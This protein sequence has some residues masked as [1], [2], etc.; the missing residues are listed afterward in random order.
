MTQRWKRFWEEYRRAPVTRDDDLFVQVGRTIGGRAVSGPEFER[1]VEHVARAL[2]LDERDVLFEFCCGNGLL[3]Y[4]L[5]A[6]VDR[7]IASDFTEHLVETA[8]S[9][10]A[11]PNVHYHVADALDPIACL[12]PSGVLPTK[13]LMGHALA[14]FGPAELE[15]VLANV[16]EATPPGTF[17]F[18]LT[19]IPDRDRMWNFYDTPERRARYEELRRRGDPLNDGLGRWWTAAELHRI[20]ASRGL[21]ADVRP[22]PEGLTDYRMDALLS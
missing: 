4:E 19:G 14:H 22:E 20:A 9:V 7:V 15:T 10:R 13:Y 17:A 8:R 21:R 6:R 2:R 18:L 3:T 12:L 16:C 11:R 1:S 5:A